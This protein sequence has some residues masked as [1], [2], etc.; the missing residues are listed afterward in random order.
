MKWFNDM[1][2]RTKLLV[3]FSAVLALVMVLAMYAIIQVRNINAE[4]YNVINHPVATREAILQAQSNIRGFR[5]TV[6]S[7]VMYAPTDSTAAK[8]SLSREGL[9]LFEAS[10][11]ALDNYEHAVRT[12]ATLPQAY[13]DIRMNDSSELRHLLQTYHDTIFLPVLAYSLAGNHS[14]AISL[15]ESGSGIINQLVD[16]TF[17]ME[18]A[19]GILLN[20]QTYATVNM[21]DT[22]LLVLIAV[23]VVIFLVALV[24]A[25]SV[26]EGISRPIRKLVSAASDV[27]MGKMNV[28]IDRSTASKDEIG[29]L[30]R[31]VCEL[32]DV[33]RAIVHDL[34]VI[35]H[36]F[37]VSGDV[38]YRADS[39]KYQNSFREMME[40]INNILANQVKDIFMAISVLNQVTDGDF[41][42]KI[43]DLPGKKMI[44]PQT[45]RAVITNLQEIY[46]SAVY[47]AGSAANGKL[48]VMTDST[49]FKGSWAE[50]AH[51]LNNLMKVVKE[52]LDE[53]EKNVVLMSKGDFSM[54][55]GDF[56][57]QFK[58]V[59]DACNLNNN[60]TFA[61]VEEIA[62]VLTVISKGDL[63]A[64]VKRDYIG[65]YAP[66]KTALTTILDS[67]NNT[68]SDIQ[69]AVGQ[70]ALGAN[71]ISTSAM[72]LADGAVRQTASIEELSTSL[73]VI[74]ENAMQASSD[75]TSAKQSTVHS[76]EFTVQG[77][78]AVH[79][80]KETMHKIK[81]S[82]EGIVKIIDVI[83]NIAFQT[84]LLAL[85]ASV[86]AARAGEHGKGFSVVADE[87]RTLAGRS[88]RSTSDTTTIIA[89]DTKNVEDGIKAAEEVVAS[90]ETIA[91]NIDEISKLVSHIAGISGEQL[92]SIS[93]I[94]DSVTEITRVVTDTSATAEQSAASSQELNSQA[95]V[96]RQKIAFFKIR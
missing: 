38:E 78:G 1:K 56:K 86:E 62:D 16:I 67:L 40:S 47:L 58:V 96:L 14:A 7:L 89:E 11:G 94:N 43:N 3:S 53:I 9:G 49:K 22:S 95:E 12:D 29:E 76:Q 87:V 19:A 91:N 60:T 74:H 82:N 79:S 73:A 30:T 39:S 20:V 80:M 75:A 6:A 5:R 90:F 2:I 10:M 42:V 83:T 28:N 45:L 55:E 48:D 71:Q 59:K 23:S 36:E 4:Y 15:V 61:I 18:G 93:N 50:L 13:I 72:H 64:S 77:R 33:V 25:L 41:N 66:I 63:T 44:L 31:D 92:E 35:D 54:M 51:T 17:S 65:S 34:T 37:N 84:N 69:A 70:V 8:N 46:E 52:P 24:L 85:N 57:G 32:V 88:Q 27:S 26:A 21:A 68:M 81:E